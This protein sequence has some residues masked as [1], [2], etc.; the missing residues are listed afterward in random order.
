MIE[1]DTFFYRGLLRR[2]S[3]FFIEWFFLKIIG[4]QMVYRRSNGGWRFSLIRK[5]FS[6]KGTKESFFFFGSMRNWCR[7]G[8]RRY[9]LAWHR[10]TSFNLWIR[11]GYKCNWFIFCNNGRWPALFFYFEVFG[12]FC[13][14]KWNEEFKVFF[15]LIVMVHL[16]PILTLFYF[17]N[18]FE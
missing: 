7:V 9:L 12:I 5:H 11:S 17:S 3:Y 15:F 4:S 16:K 18:H 13:K 14:V 6:K 8:P 2:Y 10:K 1:E